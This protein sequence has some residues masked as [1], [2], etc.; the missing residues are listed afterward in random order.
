M[1]APV[2]RARAVRGRRQRPGPISSILEA[3]RDDDVRREFVFVFGARSTRD[4][5]CLDESET[6][7]GS[8]G[9]D[10]TFVP[11]LSEES[12]DSGW[13]GARG[14]VTDVIAGLPAELLASCDAYVC[15]PPAMVDA[16]EEQLRALR[17]EGSFFH[18]DRFLDKKTQRQG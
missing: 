8:W 15:G 13:T 1:A 14:M 16:V 12:A 4:L 5:Y 3:V 17:P 11:A 10:Y 6:L 7:A 2:D 9:A 18:A